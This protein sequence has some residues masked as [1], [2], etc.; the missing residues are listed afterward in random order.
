MNDDLLFDS[1]LAA[2]ATI[3]AV[4]DTPERALCRAILADAIEAATSTSTAKKE[5]E[6]LE[7]QLWLKSE[8]DDW[9][10]PCYEVCDFLGIDRGAM[11][12]KLRPKFVKVK[13]AVKSESYLTTDKTRSADED[14][15]FL[16]TEIAGL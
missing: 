8:S 16:H 10:L 1:E 12:K 14:R 9:V 2:L 4:P 15:V 7:A 3:N 11:L 6:R 5:Q 13:A